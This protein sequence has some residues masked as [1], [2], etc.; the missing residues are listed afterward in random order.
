MLVALSRIKITFVITKI[1][2]IKGM[3]PYLS[4]CIAT[5][6]IA[7]SIDFMKHGMTKN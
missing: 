4:D 3:K 7:D 6:C 2:V 5:F 1:I